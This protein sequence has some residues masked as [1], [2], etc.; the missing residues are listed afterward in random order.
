MKIQ[1]QLKSLATEVASLR[2][3]APK[4]RNRH[5]ELD[6]SFCALVK[7]LNAI[8]ERIS[9]LQDSCDTNMT[10]FE[11]L[12]ELY[13]RG[14]LS[15]NPDSSENIKDFARDLFG[16]MRGLIATYEEAKEASTSDSTTE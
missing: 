8:A 3:T 16:S 10:L 12:I 14:H 4:S 7:S 11:S 6:R 2:Y 1:E 15:I 9:A 13:E 5:R